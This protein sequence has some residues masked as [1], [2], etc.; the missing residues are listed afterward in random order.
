MARDWRGAMT[1]SDEMRMQ[2]LAAV[3]DY[4]A[5]VAS[6]GC[7]DAQCDRLSDQAGQ[8]GLGRN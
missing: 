2:V 7:W 8:F 3:V 5:H 4:L 1:R 6:V